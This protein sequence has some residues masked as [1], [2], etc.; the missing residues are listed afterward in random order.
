MA[1]FLVLFAR[2]PSREAREKGLTSRAGSDL[3]AAFAAGWVK[4]ARAAGAR[5]ILATPPEDLL[6]WRRA[7][8][9][10]TDLA[11]F[12][13]RGG[14][15]GS[16]LEDAARRVSRF[17]GRALLVGGD[18]APSAEAL[19]GAFRALEQGA[20]A[21]LSPAPDGGVSLLALSCADLDLL[22]SVG[23]RQPDV[24]RVLDRRL[25]ERGRRVAVVAEAPDVDGRSALRALARAA[26][27]RTLASLVRRALQRATFSKVAPPHFLPPGPR[28]SPAILRGPPVAA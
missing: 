23:P 27:L 13:Q 5:M 19:E 25:R 16:R 17:G 10:G 28:M 8:P 15:F 22:R 21:V 7:L 2:E 4:A 12:A 9:E 1:R 11:F 18:V 26:G 20:E 24:F 3:F 6:A 14:S